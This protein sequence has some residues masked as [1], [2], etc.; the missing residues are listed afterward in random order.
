MSTDVESLGSLP[1]AMSLCPHSHKL[2]EQSPPT[3][4]PPTPPAVK[5]RAM[6]FLLHNLVLFSLNMKAL[7]T[8]IVSVPLSVSNPKA[9]RQ[10][11]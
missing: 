6:W 8:S 10:G 9:E 2:G 1:E 11:P 7:S 5:P 4:P 3:A